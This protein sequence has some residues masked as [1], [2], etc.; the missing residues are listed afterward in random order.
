MNPDSQFD[1]FG[2]SQPQTN[3]GVVGPNPTNIAPQPVDGGISN[4]P[5]VNPPRLDL[6]TTP[7][8]PAG[9]NQASPI[10]GPTPVSPGL[11]SNPI[12]DV[13]VAPVPTPITPGSTNT[14]P[15][16]KPTVLTSD[17]QND[18]RPALEAN[19]QINNQ[20]DLPPETN[21][22]PVDG[23]DDMVDN[24]DEYLND[25]QLGVE[26]MVGEDGM[27]HWSANEYVQVNKSPIWFFVAGSI[28][29]GLILLDVF[30][31][32][33]YS[34]SFLVTIIFIALVILSKRP[35]QQI[36]YTLSPGKGLYVEDR[37]HPFEEFKSFGVIN[38][39]GNNFIKLVPVKRFSPGVSV[40]FPVEVGE[41][42]VDVFGEFLPMETVKLDSLDIIV[43]KL[44]I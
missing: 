16:I 32:K 19:A 25:D 18:S 35:P 1:Y 21:Y 10:V 36:N 24:E 17:Y 22:Q 31:F 23:D 6:N 2:A 44:R 27:V 3:N 37:L 9:L 12:Q 5:L 40:Y 14:A 43:R 38:D 26:D 29:L 41:A 11:Q 8:A 15:P 28:A 33:Y 39:Q 30:L 20:T 4:Q 7:P 34:F 13:V 42:I